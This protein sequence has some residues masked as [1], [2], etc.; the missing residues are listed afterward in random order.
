VPAQ[1]RLAPGDAVSAVWAREIRV[2]YLTILSFK[3]YLPSMI[4]RR[5]D[6]CNDFPSWGI[7]AFNEDEAKCVA[8]VSGTLSIAFKDGI[9]FDHQN[10]KHEDLP[11][12]VIDSIF[13]DIKQ[14]GHKH[15]A[16]HGGYMVL[17]IT[18]TSEKEKQCA[19]LLLETL[20][21]AFNCYLP[22]LPEA[23]TPHRHD[24]LRNKEFPGQD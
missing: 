19:Y 22:T 6:R 4:I 20:A 1:V 11:E 24:H 5:I 12:T 9:R 21:L 14:H 7:T 23:R 18:T 2:T 17:N 10:I 16:G 8:M 3:I 15:K 13:P